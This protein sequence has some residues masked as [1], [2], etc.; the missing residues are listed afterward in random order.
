MNVTYLICY[1]FD[2]ACG[3]KTRFSDFIQ[4]YLVI[5]SDD[6]DICHFKSLIE[7]DICT[8]ADA[9]YAFGQLTEKVNSVKLFNKCYRDFLY[10]LKLYL[11]NQQKI[12]KGPIKKAEKTAF[13]RGL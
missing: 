10:H 12:L 8:W 11:E 6:N 4:E 2:I 5:K 7:E 1:G 3:L 9:E 13:I